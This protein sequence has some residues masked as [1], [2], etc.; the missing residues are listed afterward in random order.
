MIDK[1]SHNL[2]QYCSQ[3][4]NMLTF[5]ILCWIKKEFW[6]LV[7]QPS[8]QKVA[9]ASRKNAT[10][11]K[12]RG[13]KKTPIFSIIAAVNHCDVFNVDWNTNYFSIS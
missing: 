4:E 2:M 3:L 6:E 8:D 10:F 12:F 5:V 1:T 11:A 9:A 13:I 7:P